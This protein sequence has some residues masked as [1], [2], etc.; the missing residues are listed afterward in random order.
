MPYFQGYIQNTALIGE[1]KIYQQRVMQRT[2]NVP[3]KY[4][5]SPLC[6]FTH[7]HGN[8]PVVRATREADDTVWDYGG[9]QSDS[10]SWKAEKVRVVSGLGIK[11][12]HGTYRLA[13]DFRTYGCLIHYINK[14][15]L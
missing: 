10:R 2:C 3:L 12:R 5:T 13:E 14:M 4:Q 15:G 1:V 6:Y 9:N 8:D 7:N 11:G